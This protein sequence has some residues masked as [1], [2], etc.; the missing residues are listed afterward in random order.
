MSMLGI[1]LSLVHGNKDG[2]GEHHATKIHR[3]DALQPDVPLAL[4]TAA[5]SASDH[6]GFTVLT[7]RQSALRVFASEGNNRRG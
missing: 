2:N 3:N 4:I 5:L 6:P 1:H 7:L